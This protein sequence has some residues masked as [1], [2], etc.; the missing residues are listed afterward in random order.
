MHLTLE[1][2]SSL[3][4]R[5]QHQSTSNTFVKLHPRQ[6]SQLYHEALE[7]ST[8]RKSHI[9]EDNGD[10]RHCRRRSNHWYIRQ[11]NPSNVLF[12]PLKIS[13]IAASDGTTSTEHDMYVSYNGGQLDKGESAK[14]SCHACILQLIICSIVK[15]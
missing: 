8:N 5:R 6:V 7:C 1:L 4:R 11:E 15:V 2:R 13:F 3:Q 10:H 14:M 12:L 9:V